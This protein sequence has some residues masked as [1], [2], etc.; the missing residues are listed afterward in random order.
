MCVHGHF[1]CMAKKLFLMDTHEV[2]YTQNI[3]TS[4]LRMKRSLKPELLELTYSEYA[5][6]SLYWEKNHTY[7]TIKA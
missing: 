7:A 4:W 1:L 2:H 3:S 5:D 6:V